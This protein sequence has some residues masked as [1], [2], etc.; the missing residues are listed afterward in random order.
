MPRFAWELR[1][2]RIDG[3]SN[4]NRGVRV[5]NHHRATRPRAPGAIVASCAHDRLGWTRLAYEPKN[6]QAQN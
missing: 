5:T 3:M 1:R 4:P 2:A 6:Q